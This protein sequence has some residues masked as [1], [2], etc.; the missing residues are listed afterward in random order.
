VLTTFAALIFLGEKVCSIRWA[1]V[2][3]VKIGAA[4]ISYSEQAKPKTPPLSSAAE[5]GATPP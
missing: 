3:F 5:P 4:L 1:G 2:V